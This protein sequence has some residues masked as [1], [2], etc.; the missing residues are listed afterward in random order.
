MANGRREKLAQRAGKSIGMKFH[1][2]NYIR[3]ALCPARD[4]RHADPVRALATSSDIEGGR[5]ASPSRSIERGVDGD[6]GIAGVGNVVVHDDGVSIT[7]VAPRRRLDED[8]AIC[9]VNGVHG[10]VASMQRE[11]ILAESIVLY[12]RQTSEDPMEFDD[13]GPTTAH[14]NSDGSSGTVVAGATSSASASATTVPN[15][16]TGS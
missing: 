12:C 5:A 3:N 16:G 10:D 14:N 6:P 13:G 2:Q 4:T 11:L 15:P 7:S 9:A 1:L 8:L